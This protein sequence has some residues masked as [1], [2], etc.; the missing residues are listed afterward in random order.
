ME[1]KCFSLLLEDVIGCSHQDVLVDDEFHTYHQK[2]LVVKGSVLSVMSQVEA[3]I[4][5]GDNKS[6][7]NYKFI[8]HYLITL[9]CKPSQVYPITKNQRAL[10]NGVPR[11]SDRIEMLHNLDWVE[12]LHFGSTV[13]V[14]IPTIPT[15]VKGYVYHVGPVEGE[16]GTKFGIELMVCDYLGNAQIL[17][18]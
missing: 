1:Q 5:T 16:A 6:R 2:F 13:Y 11:E 18:M 17:S 12:K 9:Y 8:D 3:K 14:T 7:H 4:I 10:L 15:P